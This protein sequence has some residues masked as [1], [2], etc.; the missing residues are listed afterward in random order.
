MKMFK[1]RVHDFETRP[2]FNNVLLLW[3]NAYVYD[4]CLRISFMV[5]A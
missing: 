1:F 4:K 2:L 3:F 5:E